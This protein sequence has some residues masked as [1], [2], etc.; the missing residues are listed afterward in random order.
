MTTTKT[1]AKK[2]AAKKPMSAAHKAQL[3]AGRSNSRKVRAFLEASKIVNGPKKRG[4]KRSV[5]SINTRLGKIELELKTA[6]VLQEV[7]LYQE[8]ADLTKERDELS[9][10]QI[11]PDTYEQLTRDF[12]LVRLDYAKTKRITRATF[13]KVGVPAAILDEAGITS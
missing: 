13:R 11:D 3:E 6:D 9:S 7:L 2:T 5:E 4:R 12:V 8:Q 1:P 10:S